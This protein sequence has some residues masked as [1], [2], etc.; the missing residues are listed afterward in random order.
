MTQLGI[1]TPAVRQEPRTIRRLFD[2]LRNVTGE[3]S[4]TEDGVTITTFVADHRIHED[5]VVVITP[6][7]SG[8]DTTRAW[9]NPSDYVIPG[10]GAAIGAEAGFYVR[11]DTTVNPRPFRYAVMG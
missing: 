3:F 8:G 10:R 9:V 6:V 11:H 2:Q 1:R 5:C 7:T 4:L